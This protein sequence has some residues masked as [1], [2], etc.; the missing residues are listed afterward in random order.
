MQ[1]QMQI[2]VASI[3]SSLLT[4][5]P[6]PYSTFPSYGSHFSSPGQL[7]SNLSN[8]NISQS[9][10]QARN[11]ATA[12]HILDV[13]SDRAQRCTNPQIGSAQEEVSSP[14]RCRVF[15]TSIR[16]DSIRS[17]PVQVRGSK[18]WVVFPLAR[19]LGR[20]ED[21]ASEEGRCSVL[22]D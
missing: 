8:T 9:S 6:I 4:R 22:V 3:M 20:A 11:P 5:N 16:F 17:G 1:L 15:H 18:A 19:S 2:L 10:L 13:P 21:V 14:V 12:L 7:P